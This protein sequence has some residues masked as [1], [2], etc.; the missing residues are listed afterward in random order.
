MTPR[1]RNSAETNEFI[2]QGQWQPHSFFA[3][4]NARM[5]EPSYGCALL[6]WRGAE[7]HPC[8]DT[9]PRTPLPADGS[10]VLGPSLLDRVQATAASCTSSLPLHVTEPIQSPPVDGT[11]PPAHETPADTHHIP[12]FAV[13]VDESFAVSSPAHL[14]EG[15]SGSPWL[16]GGISAPPQ[17]CPERA[18]LDWTRAHGLSA[19]RTSISRKIQIWTV[20]AL[21]HPGT[22]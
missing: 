21:K 1:A 15:R 17:G 14:D 11:S 22:G 8:P 10:G 12:F 16:A 2:R 5:L 18:G 7:L 3:S 19:W 9:R 6:Q 4:R 13:L 20:G